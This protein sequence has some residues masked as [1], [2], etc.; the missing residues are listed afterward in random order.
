MNLKDI[1]LG[2]LK[3]EEVQHVNW[4]TFAEIIRTTD[5][6]SRPVTFEGYLRKAETDGFVLISESPQTEEWLP[7]PVSRIS[8][9]LYFGQE[10]L[11]EGASGR[12]RLTI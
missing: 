6:S 12:V 1:I 4:K 10:S 2:L 3:P 8:E 7:V 11:N 9:L 5:H